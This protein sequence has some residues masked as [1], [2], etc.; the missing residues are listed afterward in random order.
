MSERSGFDCVLRPPVAHPTALAWV[1]DR[2]VLV[3][4]TRGGELLGVD[5]VLGVR[6][7]ADGLDETAT[8]AVHPDRERVLTVARTGR[9]RVGTLG[10]D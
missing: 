10:G 2:E 5:P 1:P 6:V 9:W 4:A 7:I 3:V 8:M